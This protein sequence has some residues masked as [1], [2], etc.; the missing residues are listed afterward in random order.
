MRY[1]T[2]N[3]YALEEVESE[4][5]WAISYGDMITLLLSFFVIFFTT[6]LQKEKIHKLNDYMSFSMEELKQIPEDIIRSGAKSTSMFDKKEL[7]GLDVKIHQANNKIMVSFG[8]F[9]FFKSGQTDIRP[10]GVAILQ[11]FVEKYMP[12]AGTY[13]L[14]IKGFTDKKKVSSIKN[15]RYK[16]NLELSALRSISAMRAMQNAGIPLNRMEIAGAGELHLIDELI[17]EIKAAS[18]SEKN[19]YSR[20][21]II[22]ISPEKESW[23]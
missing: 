11:K 3:N 13:S 12:Y 2:K 9:S 6:D 19:D 23:L 4:G 16:D 10:E 7:E 5:S 21:I 22:V 17:P 18:E 15:R 8:R 14:S 1:L 20:T